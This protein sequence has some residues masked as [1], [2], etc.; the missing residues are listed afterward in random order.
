M[1]AEVERLDPAGGLGPLRPAWAELERLGG[2]RP[3]GR[4]AA[5]LDAW[6]RHYAPRGLLGIRVSDGGDV[7]AAGLVEERSLRRWRFAGAPVTAHRGLASRP[8][9]D[10]AA[11]AA[12]RTWLLAHPGRFSELELEGTDPA[13][14]ALP[15]ATG[16]A[17]P[18][19][20]MG[21]PASLEELLAARS[22]SARRELRKARRLLEGAGA[23]VRLVPD[24]ER[25]AGLQRLVRLHT[26]RT[27]DRGEH[28]AAVDERLVALLDDLP[29][30]VRVHE[31]RID[32]DVVASAVVLEHAGVAEYHQTGMD[33]AHAHLGPGYGVLLAVVEDAMARGVRRLDLGPGEYLYKE[34]IGGVA[35]P[36][37]RVIA[38]SRSARGL[39]LR[40]A[41]AA[42]R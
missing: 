28:H 22:R 40:A 2:V 38:P 39:A 25:R 36:H 24:A 42:R 34:R 11:W 32:E 30:L 33:P 41:R 7:V 14:A 31:L 21:L 16:T 13:V 4:T 17:Q 12:L 1:R 27:A 9:A 6:C 8:G 10:A 29:G 15:G 19:Y 26:A 3:A 5:W 20:A 37:W 18:A 23:S 35:A